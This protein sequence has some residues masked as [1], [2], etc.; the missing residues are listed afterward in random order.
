MIQFVNF[1]KQQFIQKMLKNLDLKKEN[2]MKN[3][4]IGWGVTNLCNMNCSFCY[5]KKARGLNHELSFDSLK[6][7]VDKNEP[8]IESINY[9][10][11]EN[12][13]SENWIKLLIYIHKKYELDQALTTNGTLAPLIYKNVI[14]DS[15][16]EALEEVD[17]SLDFFKPVKEILSALLYTQL[18]FNSPDLIHGISPS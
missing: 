15:I 5:S 2:M 18:S 6:L 10:T 13:L 3:W 4:K 7:F 8:F 12:T 11:G 9:G 17:V 14:G 1:A 16:L